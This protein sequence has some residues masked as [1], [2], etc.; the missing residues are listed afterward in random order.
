MSVT[1]SYDED[2]GEVD[3]D[4]AEELFD[5][6]GTT[7]GTLFAILRLILLPFLVRCGF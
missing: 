6:P 4:E 5:R 7:N 2:L 1:V 3:E